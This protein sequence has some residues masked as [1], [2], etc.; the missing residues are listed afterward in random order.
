MLTDYVYRVQTGF[1][2]SNARASSSSD[3]SVVFTEP[4]FEVQ[5][6]VPGSTRTVLKSSAVSAV[7]LSQQEYFG[8]SRIFV[9]WLIMS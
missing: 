5:C 8:N 9:L 4:S 6:T 2:E 1:P 3:A 7:P